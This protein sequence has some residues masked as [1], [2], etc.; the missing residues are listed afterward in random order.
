MKKLLPK[1]I[2]NPYGF[3]LIE[4][5]VVISIMAILSLIGF[6]IFTSTQGKARDA[7]RKADIDEISKVL[8]VHFN[9]GKDQKYPPVSA[10]WFASGVIPTDPKNGATYTYPVASVTTY[11]AC[12]TLEDST[13]YCKNNQQ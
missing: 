1:T 11:Q 5:L 4:L 12:A 6:G 3:T 13:T 10:T 7:R 8:E 9:D 2:N